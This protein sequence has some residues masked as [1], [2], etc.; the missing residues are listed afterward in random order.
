[1]GHPNG[2]TAGSV[3]DE[4]FA[5]ASGVLNPDRLAERY[6]P[7]VS[8]KHIRTGLRT[9]AGSS[10]MAV[11]AASVRGGSRR[12]RSNLMATIASARPKISSSPP[13]AMPPLHRITVEEYERIIA[14]GA[15]ED[16]GRIELIDGYMVDKMGKNAEHSYSTKETVKALDR[17]LPAG[18]TW[19]QEQPVRIPA[20]DEPEPDIA[21]IRGTDADY[22]HRI[23]TAA[24]V[25]LPVEVSDSTL[26]QDR[27]VKL[28]AYAKDGI[29]VYWIVNLV[30]R[31]VEVY[32]RPTKAGRY[33]SRKDYKPGRQVPVSIAGQQVPPIAVNDILP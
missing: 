32:T 18:W 29:P 2:M 14:S 5:I 6:Q 8:T 4:W 3:T 15:L 11:K 31:Q 27:G 12:E 23:P 21:I 9:P 25:G 7:D 28:A 1:M 10:T 16:P 13:S 26:V 19:R 24:D 20:Y 33:R 30:D 22:R 17:R